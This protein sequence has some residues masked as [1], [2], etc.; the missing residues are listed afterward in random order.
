[1]ENGGPERQIN[2]VYRGVGT[3]MATVTLRKAYTL[4]SVI[5]VYFR[6]TEI[7]D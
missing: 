6:C 4:A 2:A 7:D 3:A 1:M 5:A